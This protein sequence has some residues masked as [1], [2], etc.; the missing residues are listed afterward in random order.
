MLSV[1]RHSQDR[2]QTK[3]VQI[4]ESSP[5]QRMCFNCYIVHCQWDMHHLNRAARLDCNQSFMCGSMTLK[6]K[7]LNYLWV[8]F[9]TTKP[10]DYL[11]SWVYVHHSLGVLSFKFL[12]TAYFSLYLPVSWVCQPLAYSNNHH[13]PSTSESYRPQ[14]ILG[15]SA[16]LICPLRI[17]HFCGRGEGDTYGQLIFS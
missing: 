2:C 12:L 1:K 10:N 8:V 4:V 14:S 5:L 11:N 9:I 13:S 3:T 16:H 15:N 6:T 7:Q 17:G